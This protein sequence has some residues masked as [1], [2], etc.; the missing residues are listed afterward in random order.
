MADVVDLDPSRP[1]I[2]WALCQGTTKGNCLNHQSFAPLL[3]FAISPFNAL[4]NR[5]PPGDQLDSIKPK[6][7]SA[8]YPNSDRS[9]PAIVLSICLFH[10]NSSTQR[11]EWPLLLLLRRRNS[12]GKRG[13]HYLAE[14][15]ISRSPYAGHPPHANRRF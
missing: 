11:H 5:A 9:K 3:G 12:R 14:P 15:P 6:S 13:F 10:H 7:N 2:R 1:P 4:S 8:G